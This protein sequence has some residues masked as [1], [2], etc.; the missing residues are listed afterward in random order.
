MYA[1]ATGKMVSGGMG[2]AEVGCWL[3]A[4]NQ[5]MGVQSDGVSSVSLAVTLYYVY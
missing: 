5:I 1:K 3:E 2:L 4:C